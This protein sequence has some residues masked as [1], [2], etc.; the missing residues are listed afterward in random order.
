M[1]GRAGGVGLVEVR[2]VNFVHGAEICNVGEE[3]G[4]LDHVLEGEAGGLQHGAQIF[5]HL[6]GLF[7]DTAF[8][9]KT[10]GGIQGN[11]SGSNDQAVGADGLG[12]G[13]HGGGGL[14]GVDHIVHGEN[15]FL[16]VGVGAL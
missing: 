15:S 6:G 9:Q 3:D 8:H 4:G 13:A 16:L 2:C 1:N 10:G 11:L 5:K 7:H 14:I 12:I